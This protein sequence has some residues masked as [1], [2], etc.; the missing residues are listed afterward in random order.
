MNTGLDFTVRCISSLEKVFADEPLKAPEFKQASALKG[1]VYSF[2]VAYHTE[3]RHGYIRVRAESDLPSPVFVRRVGLSPSEYPIQ[4]GKGE[5]DNLLRDKPGLYPDP[6]YP[7]AEGEAFRLLPDQWRAVWVTAEIGEDV[8]AGKYDIRVHFEMESGEHLATETFQLEVI[9]AKLPPQKLIHTEWFHTDCLAV[10]YNVEV[11]SEEHWR[12]IEQYVETAVKHGINT[13]LT[14]LFTPPLD[15]AVGGERPTVQLVDVV[16]NGDRYTFGFDKLDRWIEL[17]QS[18]GIQNFEMS[19]LF[20]QWG[21]AHAPKIMA[22]EDGVEKRIFG[23]ETDA[24]GEQYRNFLDQFLPEIVKYVKNKGL[25][26]NVFFHVSDEPRLEHLESYRAAKEAVVHH[27]EGFTIM[28]ALSSVE[29]YRQGLVRNPIPANNHIDDFIAENVPNLWTY[30]C[31]SQFQKVSNRFFAFPS[32]RNRIIGMQLFKFDIV[33]FLH[34]GYNFWFT[35]FSL[36]AIDPFKVTDAGGAFPSGDPFLVYPGE[37]GPIESIRMEVFYEA[38]QD[39]RALQL[40]ESLV[41]KEKA[42]ELIE[43]D[44]EEKLT[45]DRYPTEAE[46]LLKKREQINRAIAEAVNAGGSM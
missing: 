6:L 22:V 31:V 12:R 11:F 29:F 34:W 27:L 30:Y 7:I 46:W 41:G 40:L 15:T 16:K 5:V 45:F 24:A 10:Y 14:P 28:D 43:G 35:Q 23:W 18:K 1:E 19:H 3:A 33:G 4:R 26:N 21:A 25:E 37:D 36:K 2:Q 32:A 38:L 8:P 39:L 42:L 9:N 44:L 20:T 13:I 17:C